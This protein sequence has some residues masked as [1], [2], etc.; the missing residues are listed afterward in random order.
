MPR[1][2]ILTTI[3]TIAIATSALSPTAFA[4]GGA[5]GHVGGFGGAHFGGAHLG[6]SI[7]AGRIAGMR[8]GVAPGPANDRVARGV[9][10]GLHRRDG[11]YGYYDGGYG[12]CSWPE[13]AQLNPWYCTAY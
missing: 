7:G 13:Y 10:R 8:V 3:A 9:G 4:R 2:M 11:F 1:K 12:D 5:G 6:G